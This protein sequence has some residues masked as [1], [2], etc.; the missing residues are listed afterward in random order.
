MGIYEA[1]L[2][3]LGQD[4]PNRA[5]AVRDKQTVHRPYSRSRKRQNN[6]MTTAV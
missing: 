5:R 1:Y 2:D 4:G 3:K 6:R